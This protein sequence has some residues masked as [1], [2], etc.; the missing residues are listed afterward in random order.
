M[1]LFALNSFCFFFSFYFPFMCPVFPGWLRILGLIALVVS[2][3]CL[4]QRAEGEG[5]IAAAPD[6]ELD[7]YGPG[8]LR[9][10]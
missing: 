8:A 5:Q 10:G 1:L 6:G 9:A 7:A 2:C 4:L 3:T